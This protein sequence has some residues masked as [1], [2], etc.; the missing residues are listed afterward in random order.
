MHT[1]VLNSRVI[2]IVR[3]RVQQRVLDSWRRKGLRG[4]NRW[5]LR[6]KCISQE[7]SSVTWANT[8][9]TLVINC[10]VV[11]I[12]SICALDLSRRNSLRRNHILQNKFMYKV[13]WPFLHKKQDL[14]KTNLGNNQ[15]FYQVNV[16][17]GMRD[18]SLHLSF[19]FTFMNLRQRNWRKIR[20]DIKSNIQ[21]STFLW[22]KW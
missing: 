8:M 3:K 15:T 16:E 20:R 5:R 1:S 7:N 4:N 10:R 14:H 18:F 21:L 9:P 19:S 17:S 11:L 13:N 12:Y 22:T 6:T 2:L